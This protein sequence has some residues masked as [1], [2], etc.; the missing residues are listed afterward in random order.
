[1][2][3]ESLPYP[4][5]NADSRGEGRPKDQQSM[6]E[7]TL[8]QSSIS[9]PSMM[10]K[11]VHICHIMVKAPRIAFGAHSAAYTGVVLDLAP[12]ASPR[13]KRAMIRHIQLLAAACHIPVTKAKRQEKAMVSRRPKYLFRGALSQ[14]PM[15]AAEA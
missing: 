14:H 3:S 12:T 4:C 7:E 10:P 13:V 15:R 2:P 6:V 1:M 9:K 8:S 5:T 11:A